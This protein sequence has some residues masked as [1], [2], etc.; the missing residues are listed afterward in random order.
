V[1][2]RSLKSLFDD[3][4]EEEEPP[5]GWP[6]HPPPEVLER[7]VRAGLS[8]AENRAVV[9]HLLTQCPQCRYITGRLWKLS[10][11][12]P[13]SIEARLKREMRRLW[14]R[15]PSRPT[16]R[17]TA[18]AALVKGAQ[19]ML[20]EM[21]TVLQG[22]QGRLEG[23]AAALPPSPQGDP[24]LDDVVTELRNIIGTVLDDRLRPAI[25]DL[26]DAAYYPAEPPANEGSAP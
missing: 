16:R 19:E 25:A 3:D 9:R 15:T 24:E 8:R 10:E 7:F 5:P 18:M 20:L 2:G 12:E 6:E 21:T 17:D 26:R 11:K 4:A 1:S 14:Q 23:M 13:I 22:I